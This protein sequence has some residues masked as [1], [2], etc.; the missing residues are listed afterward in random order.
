MSLRALLHRV[1]GVVD[2]PGA[3]LLL[4]ASEHVE[5]A[6]DDR[7]EVVEIVRDAR[8]ELCNG[9]HL[10]RLVRLRACLFHRFFGSLALADVSRDLGES[11][12]LTALVADRLDDD[13][14][15]EQASILADL[16]ALLLIAAFSCGR[17]EA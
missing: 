15:K 2:Q 3:T 10:L 9:G 8:G 1:Q 14:G 4:G 17:R 5:I 16:P 11:N 12:E 13:V 6:H 7:Q